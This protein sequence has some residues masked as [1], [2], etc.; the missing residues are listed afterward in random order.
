MTHVVPLHDPDAVVSA[1]GSWLGG[2]SVDER[3][4]IYGAAVG[5]RATDPDAA[6]PVGALH[7][8]AYVV[9]A[10]RKSP[11]PWCG[12]PL[13]EHAFDFAPHG[14]DVRCLR[15]DRLLPAAD[16]LSGP[17]SV[18]TVYRVASFLGWVGLPLISLGLLAWAMPLVA[19]IAR[20]RRS[21]VAAAGA[22]FAV[23]VAGAAIPGDWGGMLLLIAW[24][25]GTAYGGFQVMPWLRSKPHVARARRAYPDARS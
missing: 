8:A 6:L 24:W 11:C 15:T 18:S 25:G 1:V 19:G 13:A 22:L 16:W 2:L 5:L 7:S 3:V 12:Q 21:W 4:A 20:R 23:A 14:T 9:M 17:A 10:S